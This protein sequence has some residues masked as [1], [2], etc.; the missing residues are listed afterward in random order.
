MWLGEEV[1]GYY[2][3]SMDFFGEIN[4]LSVLMIMKIIW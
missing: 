2:Y 4:Y 3:R 1:W